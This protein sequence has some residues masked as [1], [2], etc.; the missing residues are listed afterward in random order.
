LKFYDL[1]VTD[2]IYFV[3][4]THYASMDLYCRWCQR[5]GHIMTS[6]LEIW[7]NYTEEYSIA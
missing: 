4:M 5:I 1:F 2:V 7:Q 6:L 3:N